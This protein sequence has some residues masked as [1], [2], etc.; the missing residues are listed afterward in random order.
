MQDIQ[1]LD[2]HKLTLKL[3]ML[4]KLITEGQ[5]AQTSHGVSDIKILDKKIVISIISLIE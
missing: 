4:M 5:R 1:T 2:I 3:V